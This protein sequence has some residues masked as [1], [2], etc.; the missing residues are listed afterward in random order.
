M[1]K[2]FRRLFVGMVLFF[3]TILI[4]SCTNNNPTKLPD[5]ETSIG[6]MFARVN[7]SFTDEFTYFLLPYSKYQLMITHS[8]PYSTQF[9]THFYVRLTFNTLMISQ[10]KLQRLLEM[11]KKVFWVSPEADFTPGELTITLPE[12]TQNDALEMFLASYSEYDMAIIFH[13]KH[14]N[15]IRISFDYHKIEPFDMLDRLSEDSLV[16]WVSFYPQLPDWIQGHI[17][18]VLCDNIREDSEINDFILSYS[19]YEMTKNERHPRLPY[20]FCITFNPD[21]I[22]EFDLI[23]LLASDPRVISAY[24][25]CQFYEE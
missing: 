19:E 25:Q 11:N 22:D 12:H 5:N 16:Q 14:Q 6:E 7:L 9:G 10:T 17:S 8:L 4:L 20:C 13:D 2:R 15:R 1:R 18:L 21:T 3:A 24:F 23:N